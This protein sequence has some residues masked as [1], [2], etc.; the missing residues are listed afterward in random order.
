LFVGVNQ[1][2]VDKALRPLQFAV[3][4]AIAQA[5]LFVLDLKLLPPANTFL[6][7]SGE[8]T[9]TSAKTQLEALRSAGVKCDIATKPILLQTLYSVSDLAAGG[10]DLLIMSLSSHGFEQDGMAYVLLSDGLHTD[11]QESGLSLTVIEQRLSRS[12]AGK[13]LLLVDACRENPTASSRGAGDSPMSAAFRSALASAKGKVVLA[14]CD[15]G[16]L[17]LENTDLGHGVFTFYLLDALKGN[18][19]V[20]S[21]GFI[22]LGAVKNYV[23]QS[24]QDWVVKNRPGVPREQAQHPWFKGPTDAEQIP[25]AVDPGVRA[26]LGSFKGTVVQVVPS[27]RTKINRNGPFTTAVCGRLA[28]ALEKA[29]D[30]DASRTLLQ[31]SQDFVAGKT[32][33]DV[34][35]AYLEKALAIESVPAAS[36]PW[37]NSLGMKFVPI[38]AAGVLFS[39]WETRV[40]DYAAYAN[41]D[42][43]VNTLWRNPELGEP[44]TPD[45]NCP[46]VNVSSEDAKAFC[47]WLTQKEQAEGRLKAGQEY[48]LP[49]NGEWDM[50]YGAA[51]FPWGNQWP[52]PAGVGNFADATTKEKISLLADECLDSY[53]DGYA[54]TA[55]VGSFKPN[56]F[57][58]FDMNGN[59]SEWCENSDAAS[60]KLKPVA[61]GGSWTDGVRSSSYRIFGGDASN[62]R[63][64]SVGFRCV[65]TG[66][67]RP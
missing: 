38:E 55:P 51:V 27:L 61:R 4:D 22:T 25:L 56:R 13:Q 42:S 11:L 41:A 53:R 10:D 23:A 47:R 5:H 18:A 29:Q 46:V 8:P 66:T 7:L 48:R 19:P 59:V 62:Y 26:K 63:T 16:Q 34:F 35:V 24:V 37:T 32:A 60:K 15:T 12:K 14:S 49:T 58:L 44:V 54:T 33:E 64:A 20:D 57:G 17:S 52:P 50:A 21:R 31:H 30:N 3:N 67:P 65:L 6:A 45:A 40:K 1:F 2:T 9:T 39:I 43:S 36:G 28:N